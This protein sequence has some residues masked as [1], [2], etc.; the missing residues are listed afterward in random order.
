FATCFEEQL[1]E[2]DACQAAQLAYHGI[3]ANQPWTAQIVVAALAEDRIGR[4]LYDFARTRLACCSFDHLVPL[5]ACPEFLAHLG[6]YPVH[7]AAR[8]VPSPAYSTFQALES[9]T[10][11]CLYGC[12]DCVVAPEQNLHGI[13]AARE[14]VNKSL[15]D[16]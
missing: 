15:L 14:T 10:G 8:L 3:A 6:N 16:A 7:Q 5:Q 1:H 11:F 13:L 4:A 9:A 12:V 2:C